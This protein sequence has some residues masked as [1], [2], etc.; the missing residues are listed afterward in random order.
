MEALI[1]LPLT[2]LSISLVLL[3]VGRSPTVP[4]PMLRAVV[5]G[6]GLMALGDVAAQAFGWDSF[7][8]IVGAV[9]VL[10]LLIGPALSAS[11]PATLNGPRLSPAAQRRT[12]Q[13]WMAVGAVVVLASFLA[14]ANVWIPVTLAA[15]LS[16]TL[17]VVIVGSR[18]DRD[19]G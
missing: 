11:D 1:G 18:R 14:P 7:R 19:E 5:L 2:F 16:V 6:L 10:C 8:I 3:T 15:G 4:Q 13:A 9:G 17:A 12:G